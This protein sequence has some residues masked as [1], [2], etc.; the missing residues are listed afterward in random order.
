[1]FVLFT[2][3]GSG[4]GQT[5]EP[6]QKGGRGETCQARNDCSDGL[7]CIGGICSKNDFP[8][9]VTAKQCVSIQCVTKDDCCAALG[10]SSVCTSL[11]AACSGGDATSCTRYN[12]QCGCQ[13]DCKDSKCVTAATTCATD[14]DCFSGANRFCVAG[15]CVSCKADLDCGGTRKCVDGTCKTGCTKNEECAFFNEC[16]AGQC[17]PT[18]CKSD[19][20]CY[21]ATGNPLAHCAPSTMPMA[22]GNQCSVPC[23]KDVEC[24]SSGTT[25]V[26]GVGRF[27]KCSGGQCVFVGCDTSEECRYFLGIMSSTTNVTAVC[28]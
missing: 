6:A 4:A 25:G 12:T 18:G 24:R 7:A 14:T 15:T 5:V 8:I 10:V 13:Q 19:R 27:Q 16:Q 23:E 17:V 28:K 26:T 3:C 2:G 1:M 11:K 21:G 22:T 20:E 9:A